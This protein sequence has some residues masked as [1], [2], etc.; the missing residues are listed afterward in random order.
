MR[1]FLTLLDVTPDEIRHLLESTQR[2]KAAIQ[3]GERPPTLLGRVLGLV[4][5]KPSLR[6]R[7]SFQAAMAQG[8]GTSLFLAGNDVGLGSRESVPDFARIMSRYVDGVVLRTF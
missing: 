7:V 5:E 3:R 4:F 2:G 6:T 1:H 8:G